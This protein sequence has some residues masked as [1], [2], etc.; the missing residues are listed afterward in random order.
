MV[1]SLLKHSNKNNN[2]RFVNSKDSACGPS[3]ELPPVDSE[4][5][6]IDL[7]HNMAPRMFHFGHAAQ[8]K[9]CAL[10]AAG[11]PLSCTFWT[12]YWITKENWH[13]QTSV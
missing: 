8:K 5:F 1:F 11:A 7:K 13:L 12:A 10:A 6:R 9:D 3:P 4:G 2:T